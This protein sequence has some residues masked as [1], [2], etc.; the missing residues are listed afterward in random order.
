MLR[1]MDVITIASFHI[2]MGKHHQI[3]DKI[4]TLP[5]VRIWI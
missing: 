5:K 2:E 3:F 1:I 4:C